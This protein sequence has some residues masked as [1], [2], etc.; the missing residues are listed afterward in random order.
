MATLKAEALFQRYRH[1][2]RPV[3]HYSLGWLPRWARLASV[4]PRTVNRVLAGP[5][6]P[7]GKRVA[8]VDSRRDL[9]VFARQTF[10]RWFA[11]H[12]SATGDPVM[13]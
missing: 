11:Q 2:P 10:R 8:G 7:F 13:L 12:R 4:M 9:P 6:A 3:T 1:R 5:V